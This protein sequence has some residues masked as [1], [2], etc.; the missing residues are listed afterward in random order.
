MFYSVYVCKQKQLYN[1]FCVVSQELYFFAALRQRALPSVA[2]SRTTFGGTPVHT[3]MYPSSS[4]TALRPITSGTPSASTNVPV[5]S[6]PL[7]RA[8]L[9]RER[10][11]LDKMV[12][13][14]VG[15]GPTN[16]YALICQQCF[17]HNGNKYSAN[18]LSF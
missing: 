4:S 16:R 2:V 10:S 18:N 12:D 14:L 6:L 3:R 13:Y 1:C 8:I 11:V 9:P 15:D 7:P 17:S 5:P